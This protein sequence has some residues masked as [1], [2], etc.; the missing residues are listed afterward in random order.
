MSP[1]LESDPPAATS[2]GSSL[3]PTLAHE[4]SPPERFPDDRP[5]A[6]L[7]TPQDSATPNSEP[8]APFPPRETLL[9]LVDIFFD[10]F[11]TFLPIFHRRELASMAAAPAAAPPLLLYAVLA[12]TAGNHPDPQVRAFGTSWY[13]EA[14]DLYGSTPY[15][16]EEP[17]RTL[18]AAACIILQALMVGEHSTA[19]LVLGRAWRQAVALG[20]HRLDSDEPPRLPNVTQPLTLGWRELEQA[21]RTIWALF[22]FDRG[23][24]FPVGLAHAVDE[25]QLRVTLPMSED[26]FQA[27]DLVCVSDQMIDIEPGVRIQHLGTRLS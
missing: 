12:V 20:F 11:Y 13:E 14:K 2:Q 3:L 9:E 1:L 5:A 23:M 4:R 21:R 26:G 22:M 19:W 25:R 8:A 7:E 27:R 6:P 24:C 10:R 16:P 18:Q 15:Q 17:L